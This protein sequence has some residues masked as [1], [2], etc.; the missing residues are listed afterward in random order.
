MK[1]IIEQKYE[2]CRKME[3]QSGEKTEEQLDAES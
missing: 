1:E 3:I 2:E